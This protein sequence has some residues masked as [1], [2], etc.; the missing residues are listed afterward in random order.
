MTNERELAQLAHTF[1]QRVELRGAEA[2]RFIEVL[3]WLEALIATAEA[4]TIEEHR[5]AA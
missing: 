2:R 1:L 3:G 5:R 4:P